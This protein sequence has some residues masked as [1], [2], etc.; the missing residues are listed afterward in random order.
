MNLSCEFEFVFVF[1][2]AKLRVVRT[3]SSMG[4]QEVPESE[5]TGTNMHVH[6]GTAHAQRHYPR[7]PCSLIIYWKPRFQGLLSARLAAPHL[8]GAAY[9]YLVV[10]MS[11]VFVASVALVASVACAVLTACLSAVAAA[12]LLASGR[13]KQGEIHTRGASAMLDQ[14]RQVHSVSSESLLL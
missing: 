11:A 1:I 7:I 3:T 9:H 6:R 2:S 10:T 14:L 5:Y 8:F 12:S 13:V 4:A